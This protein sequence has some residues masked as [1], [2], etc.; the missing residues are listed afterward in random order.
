MLGCVDVLGSF[1]FTFYTFWYLFE[2]VVHTYFDLF[3]LICGYI[4]DGFWLFWEPLALPWRT[5]NPHLKR[6]T[7]QVQKWVKKWCHLEP[8]WQPLGYVWDAKSLKSRAS[9]I[10]VYK[11]G[12]SLASKVRDAVLCWFWGPRNLQNRETAAE[13]VLFSENQYYGKCVRFVST[14]APLGRHFV[15]LGRPCTVLDRFCKTWYA[16]RQIVRENRSQGKEMEGN[17]DSWARKFASLC[18]PVPGCGGLWRH[19]GSPKERL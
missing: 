3:S 15:P 16:G 7:Q 11:C 10:F 8:P 4:F 13:W 2:P 6:D 19:H 18:P 5:L 1:Q 17:I 14:L 12:C 9:L